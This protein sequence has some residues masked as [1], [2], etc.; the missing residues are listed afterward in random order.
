ML[1]RG[2]ALSAVIMLGLAAAGRA[3][4]P[5][6]GNGLRYV[7]IDTSRN[8][9][10][11]LP[12]S[13]LGQAKPT[14][15]D[16]LHATV[17]KVLPFTAKKQPSIFAPQRPATPSPR[18]MQAQQAQAQKPPAKPFSLPSIGSFFSGGAK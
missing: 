16:R 10:T 9:A 5:S 6:G 3:Q 17:A 1:R 11:P 4:V 12:A 14:L 15:S 8:L 13:N 18:G 2:I 7:P